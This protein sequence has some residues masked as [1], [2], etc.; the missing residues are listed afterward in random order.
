MEEIS[1]IKFGIASFGF[2]LLFQETILFIDGIRPWWR[3]VVFFA[4]LIFFGEG[5]YKFG[6]YK[7]S[8]EANKE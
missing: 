5:C 6:K 1:W 4:T 3:V 2:F 8:A 7:G